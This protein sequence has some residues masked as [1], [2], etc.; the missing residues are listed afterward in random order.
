MLTRAKSC[1]LGV[2]LRGFDIQLERSAGVN[3]RAPASHLHKSARRLFGHRWLWNAAL[4]HSYNSDNGIGLQKDQR[5]AGRSRHPSELAPHSAS[6]PPREWCEQSFRK[7][8]KFR[9]SLQHAAAKVRMFGSK[10]AAPAG[11]R[12]PPGPVY[13]AA[14]GGWSRG[15]PWDTQQIR[16]G[17]LIVSPDKKNTRGHQRS[18]LILLKLLSC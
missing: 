10:E 1:V 13:Q 6:P 8:A 2:P 15:R 4:P 5:S 7:M 18:G 14:T 12:V 9:D 16:D 3:G 11:F 17:M